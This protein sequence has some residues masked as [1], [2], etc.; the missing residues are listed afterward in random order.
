MFLLSVRISALVNRW[1]ARSVDAIVCRDAP[2][3]HGVD[4]MMKRIILLIIQFKF[5]IIIIYII[6]FFI[7]SSFNEMM[8]YC[9]WCG[10]GV[11]IVITYGCLNLI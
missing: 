4:M 10:Y 3:W 11:V 6:I 8:I 9:W 1:G 2:T 7:M 5:F